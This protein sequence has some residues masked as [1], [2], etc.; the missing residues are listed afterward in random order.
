MKIS[1]TRSIIIFLLLFSGNV[2]YSQTEKGKFLT[3]GQ[4]I[5]NFASTTNSIS[6]QTIYSLQD[7]QIQNPV[8]VS[9]GRLLYS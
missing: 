8:I 7:R 5:L 4:Y 9:T 3:G 1:I 2:L 6:D